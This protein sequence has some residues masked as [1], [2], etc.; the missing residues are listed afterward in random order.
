MQYDVWIQITA[1]RAGHRE[2]LGIE[3]GSTTA[4]NGGITDIPDT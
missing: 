4:K 3:D 1:N 2:N